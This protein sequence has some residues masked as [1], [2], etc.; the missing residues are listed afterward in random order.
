MKKVNL[1]DNCFTLMELLLAITLFSIIAVAIYSSLAV[2]IKV[3]RRGSRIGGGY[4]DLRLFFN[5]IS[6]DLRTAVH[7]NNIYLVEESQK[8]YFFSIQSTSGGIKELYKITYT[9]EM[10]KDYFAL[11]RLKETY[12]DSL[13][14]TH[15]KGDE[16]LDRISQLSFDYGYLKK[17]MSGEEEFQWKE[18]WKQEAMPKMVRLGLEYGGEK[19]SKIIYCPSGKMGEVKEE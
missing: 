15:P 7:I 6:Q 3:H 8:I 18:D 17:G 4:G 14:D 16:I 12:I 1:K 5:R 2:G 10:E 19:F 13:Q 11:L 9:W